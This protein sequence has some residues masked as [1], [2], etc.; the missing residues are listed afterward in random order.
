M[1]LRYKVVNVGLWLEPELFLIL[2]FSLYLAFAAST[3]FD[4]LWNQNDL[5]QELFYPDH[6]LLWLKVDRLSRY[7]QWHTNQYLSLIHISEP[8][9][10]GMISYAVFC[11]KK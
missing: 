2:L 3:C 11:L 10:L 6:L 7:S 4:L 8:T 9:R 1:D 5:R